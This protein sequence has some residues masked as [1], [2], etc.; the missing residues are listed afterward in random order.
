MTNLKEALARQTETPLTAERLAEIRAAIWAS[1]CWDQGCTPEER[2]VIVKAW[3]R[4]PGHYSFF[5]A[6]TRLLREAQAISPNNP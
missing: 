4:M 3:N 2:A 6:V 5:D 1:H